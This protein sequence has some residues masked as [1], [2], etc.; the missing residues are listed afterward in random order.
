MSLGNREHIILLEIDRRI[1]MTTLVDKV[2]T[3]FNDSCIPIQEKLN[4]FLR[5]TK[6]KL[7][8][9]EILI[10]N[11]ILFGADR[12][13]NLFL[14]YW[15]FVLEESGTECA[16]WLQGGLGSDLAVVRS[17]RKSL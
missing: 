17:R 12:R 3:K 7:S 13:S 2:G 6:L 10:F 16:D 1:S 15:A 11:R 9:K 8:V 5:N 4:I 14:S